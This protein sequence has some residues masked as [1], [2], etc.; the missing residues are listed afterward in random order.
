[1]NMLVS[2]VLSSTFCKTE[3][4]PR[5][6]RLSY[7]LVALSGFGV[8]MYLKRENYTCRLARHI[9]ALRTLSRCFL[10]W[11]LEPQLVSPNTH[12]AR[13]KRS[14]LSMPSTPTIRGTRSTWSK[15]SII[16]RNS[17][18]STSMRAY[19]RYPSLQQVMLGGRP[20]K[21]SFRFS[22]K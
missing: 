17:W 3:N 15:R 8:W 6:K 21:P 14:V 16:L 19:R 11:P 1:M 7:V 18:I 13:S 22:L 5:Q 12:G 10:S 20:W 2:S 9:L 4:A